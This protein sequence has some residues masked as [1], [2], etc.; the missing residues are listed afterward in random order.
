[1]AV[2]PE[3]PGQDNLWLEL[4]LL[5]G[6]YV[7]LGSCAHLSGIGRANQFIGCLFRIAFSN[8]GSEIDEF[9]IELITA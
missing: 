5:Q 6:F 2:W 3:E 8:G 4:S 1:M 9:I 7:V